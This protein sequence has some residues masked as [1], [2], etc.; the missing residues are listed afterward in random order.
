MMISLRT[1][2]GM[3]MEKENMSVPVKLHGPVGFRH[4]L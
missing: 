4:G 2:Q 1:V 3:A